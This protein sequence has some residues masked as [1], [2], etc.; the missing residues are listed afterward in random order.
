MEFSYTQLGS[1]R[2]KSLHE[3]SADTPAARRRVHPDAQDFRTACA[4][5]AETPHA[6]DRAANLDDEKVAAN[7]DEGCLDVG[8]VREARRWFLRQW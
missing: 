6:N 2:L 1:P 3:L 4:C 5:P 8:E 7:L